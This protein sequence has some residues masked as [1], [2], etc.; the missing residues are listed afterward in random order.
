MQLSEHEKTLLIKKVKKLQSDPELYINKILDM[1]ET[2]EPYHKEICKAVVEYDRIAIKACHAVGKTWLGGRLVPWFLNCF[3]GSI[4]ITTAPTNRQV[5]TLLWGEIRK[6][7]KRSKTILGGKLLTKKWTIDDDWYAMGFSPKSASE[8]AGDEQ[9]GSSFQGF[10]A[11]YVFIFFDEAT[12][13]S[14]DIYTMAEGLLTSGVIVK[15]VCIANPTT[16]ASEFFNICKKSEWHVITINCFDSPNMKANGFINRE[17]LEVEISHLKTLTDSER[18]KRIKNYAK[19]NGVLLSAQWVVSKIFDWGFNHPLTKSKILGEFPNTADNVIVKWESVQAAI[20]RDPEYSYEKRF[21]G[22]DVARFG[23]DLTVL[24]ELTD[25]TFRGYYK[26]YKEDTVETTGRVV[27]LFR[28]GDSGKETHIIVDG[29]G[30]GAGVV[31][32]LN[33]LKYRKELPAHVFIHEIHF[34]SKI[35]HAT[36]KENE[37]LNTT[38][39]NLKAF[40]F[41]QLDKD[42]LNN[43]SIPD[44]EIYQDELPS[45]LFKYSR[46]GKLM[47]ESKDDYKARRGKSPDC[48]DSLALA[49][50][51][52][53]LKPTYGTFKKIDP[54]AHNNKYSS[55]YNARS[56]DRKS[57]IKV[58]TY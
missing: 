10:H 5:E 58:K 45:I 46:S 30:I 38:Y 7:Y 3:K 20:N 37:K 27:N 53:Y 28:T 22:V 49:N 1:G 39:E 57:K 25:Y 15:W 19:P 33:D 14:K 23:N 44:E 4:V 35:T 52:R 55:K 56:E 26:H 29:T 51:G 41:D 42:L 32:M 34:A 16:T 17:A 36:E 31:D 40:L 43:L 8:N 6:V 18:L 50:Y 12:G 21:I 24:T 11:K 54:N 2:L 13:I 9:Q 47:V 48:A